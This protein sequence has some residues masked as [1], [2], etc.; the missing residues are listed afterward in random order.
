MKTKIY[1]GLTHTNIEVEVITNEIVY[2]FGSFKTAWYELNGEKLFR[3]ETKG[4]SG[5]SLYSNGNYLNA[6][7]GKQRQVSGMDG[8]TGHGWGGS[9]VG[10]YT[11]EQ[12]NN[13][14]VKIK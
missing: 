6:E 8:S 5:K 9:V 4:K 7:T 1:N 3:I 11:L 2:P 13:S 12:I 14:T 10:F